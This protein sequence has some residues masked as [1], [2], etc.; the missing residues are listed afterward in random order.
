[1]PRKMAKKNRTGTQFVPTKA[2]AVV[3][4]DTGRIV[5]WLGTYYVAKSRRVAAHARADKKN[6]KVVR[7]VVLVPVPEIPKPRKRRV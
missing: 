4:K 1:M 3:D 5:Q 2:W 6:E 7:C